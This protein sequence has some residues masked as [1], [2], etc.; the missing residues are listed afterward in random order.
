MNRNALNT[1]SGSG[2]V[3]ISTERT[4]S[5][6]RMLMTVTTRVSSISARRS[7]ATAR[8]MRAERS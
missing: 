5:R 1:A 7:V 4:L 6:N 2:I 3:T 8:S